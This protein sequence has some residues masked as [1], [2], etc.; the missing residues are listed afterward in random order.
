MPAQSENFRYALEQMELGNK[1]TRMS[2]P[3]GNFV[4]RL[5]GYTQSG[6][7]WPFVQYFEPQTRINNLGSYQQC[8]A[9]HERFLTC[10]PYTPTNPDMTANDWAVYNLLPIPLERN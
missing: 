2:W 9:L 7:W 6:S 10:Q 3:P 1:V 8:F 4:Y 5:V